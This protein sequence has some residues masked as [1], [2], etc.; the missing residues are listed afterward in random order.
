MSWFAISELF[1]D[2]IFTDLT[3][4]N[5]LLEV[6][7]TIADLKDQWQAL[8]LALKLDPSVVKAVSGSTPKD[9]LH[10]V[11]ELWLR[12]D[13]VMPSWQELV[14]C[15]LNRLWRGNSSI[16]KKIILEHPRNTVPS[17]SCIH[18]TEI[19]IMQNCPYDTENNLVIFHMTT[20]H[21]LYSVQVQ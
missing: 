13:K 7:D 3:D 20:S 6:V 8:G 12:H 10:K 1:N 4:E 9:C 21:G 11:V 17:K 14:D 5:S 2:I 16:I 19:I 15:L 18:L